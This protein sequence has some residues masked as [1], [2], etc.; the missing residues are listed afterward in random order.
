MCGK[1][2][3][4]LSVDWKDHV[5][6]T[7]WICVLAYLKLPSLFFPLGE[8]HRI[9]SPL[10]SQLLP[11]K[12]VGQRTRFA[13]SRKASMWWVSICD[14]NFATD[15]S[16]PIPMAIARAERGLLLMTGCTAVFHFWIRGGDSGS[17][18]G[19]KSC[20]VAMRT[21][22]WFSRS[23]IMDDRIQSRLNELSKH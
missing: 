6:S 21:A 9:S 15:S 18:L 8:I 7:W 17:L 5:S 20:K 1:R 23:P 13:I 14:C 3:D 2:P 22:T 16:S 11:L 19:V 10:S 4:S 12:N